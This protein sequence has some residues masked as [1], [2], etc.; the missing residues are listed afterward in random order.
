[1]N[2][3]HR[4]ERERPAGLAQG[5]HAAAD[6]VPGLEHDDVEPVSG[7][8]AGRREPRRPGPHDQY[9]GVATAHADRASDR[10]SRRIALAAGLT[11][12]VDRTRG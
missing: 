4:L 11:R 10:S 8:P 9:L 2:S 12:I 7:Q 6:A 5:V 1:M 3:A